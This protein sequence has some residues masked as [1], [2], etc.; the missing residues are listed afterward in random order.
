MPVVDG[1]RHAAAQHEVRA[2]VAALHVIP[3]PALRVMEE[4]N[5]SS[6]AEGAQQSCGWHSI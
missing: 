1:V 6:C 3:F 5:E 4:H 2:A